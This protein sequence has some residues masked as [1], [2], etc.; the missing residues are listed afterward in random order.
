[1]LPQDYSMAGNIR[2]N[3]V[4][5]EIVRTVDVYV[6]DFKI[7]KTDIELEGWQGNKRF[8]DVL[9]EILQLAFENNYNITERV[10]KAK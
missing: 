1:M 2:R 8:N 4:E 10:I 5:T 9:K 3:V 7:L 6:S